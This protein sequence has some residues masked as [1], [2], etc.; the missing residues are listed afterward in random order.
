MPTRS[1]RAVHQAY[2]RA[3]HATLVPEPEMLALF[4]LG[5]IALVARRRAATAACP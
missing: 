2:G 5:V 1:T 4:A 3:I